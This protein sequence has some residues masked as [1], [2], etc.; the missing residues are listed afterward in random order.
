M[1]AA[2]EITRLTE[3]IRQSDAVAFKALFDSHH[4]SIFNFLYFKL[5]EVEAAEDLT[6]EVFIRLWENRYQLRKDLSLKAYLYTIARNLALNHIRHQNI[7]LKFQRHQNG[8]YSREESASTELET[9]ELQENLMEAIA[10]LPEHSRIVFMMSRFEELS[11]K[12]IAERLKVSIKTVE[13]H[14][15]KALKLLRKSL[16]AV[17]A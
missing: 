9:N 5:K 16:Q 6:Q 3:R 15:G 4:E 13:S 11:Y 14:I 8:S 2:P 12:E 10:N 17:L 7:V 1:I